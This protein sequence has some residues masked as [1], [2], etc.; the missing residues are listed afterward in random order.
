[1]VGGSRGVG[2]WGRGPRGSGLA[3]AWGFFSSL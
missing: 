1:M 2:V 3:G